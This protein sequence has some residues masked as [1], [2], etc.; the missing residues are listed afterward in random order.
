MFSSCFSKLCST[1]QSE[2]YSE[3]LENATNNLPDEFPEEKD[4]EI[5]FNVL[6][7]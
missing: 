5:I 3:A 4:L 2:D 6:K 7:G 1:N